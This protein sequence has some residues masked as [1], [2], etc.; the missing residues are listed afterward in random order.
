MPRPVA[1]DAHPG[2]LLDTNRFER[3]TQDDMIDLG[4]ASEQEMVLAF[5]KAELNSPRFSSEYQI[6]RYTLIDLADLQSSTQNAARLEKLKKVK[7]DLLL[8]PNVVWRRAALENGDLPR[9]KYLNHRNWKTLSGDTRLV[10]DGARNIDLKKRPNN[11]TNTHIL[12][13]AKAFKEGTRYPELIGVAGEEE[14]ADIILIEGHVRATAYSLAGWP[15]HIDCFLGISPD[16]H[17]WDEA[18]GCT[19]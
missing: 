16:T 15:G 3:D 8:L 6:D 5:L 11:D 10:S 2:K 18:Y 13:V 14:G 4:P 19:H 7:G 1:E 9:L 12:A 17:N